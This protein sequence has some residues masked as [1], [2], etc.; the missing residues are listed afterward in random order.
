LLRTTRYTIVA[1]IPPD[2]YIVAQAANKVLLAPPPPGRSVYFPASRG[3]QSR[4]R[5]REVR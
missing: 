5:R 4:P 2:N 1:M 3:P